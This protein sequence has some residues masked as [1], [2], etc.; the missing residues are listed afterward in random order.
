M[1][2]TVFC[3]FF[4]LCLF[5]PLFL[6]TFCLVLWYT[7]KEISKSFQNK[8]TL[9]EST[10][11]QRTESLIHM[12]SF[13][14]KTK[15]VLFIKRTEIDF[16]SWKTMTPLLRA[17]VALNIFKLI[18][19]LFFFGVVL[20]RFPALKGNSFDFLSRV[21]RAHTLLTLEDDSFNYHVID[22]LK[23]INP[24]AGTKYSKWMTSI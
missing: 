12:S 5:L 17:L 20:S 11:K 6:A 4:F 1:L 15:S 13:E 18:S 10:W 3:I 7:W 16:M 8:G 2:I 22:A 14:R 21:F 23:E 19:I 9:L 24:G